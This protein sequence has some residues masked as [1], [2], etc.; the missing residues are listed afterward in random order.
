METIKIPNTATYS[1][2]SLM[3]LAV[4]APLATRLL[5]GAT[6]PGRMIQVAALGMYAGSALADW[7]ERAGARQIDFLAEF[8][9]DVKDL[10]SMPED[11]RRSEAAALAG[12][13]ND[14]YV[15][16]EM[17]REEM[18]I[19]ADRHLTG[20]MAAITDQRIETSTEIRSFTLAKLVF[21]FALGTCDV[22]SGDVAILQDAG[23]FEPH[24]IAHEFCHR[25]GYLKELHAQALAYMALAGSGEPA[26]E[27][28]ANMER[29]H[30]S[31]RV[32]SGDSAERYH[33][34]VDEV[35]LRPELAKEFH[36]LWPVSSPM[37]KSVSTFMKKL[38]DERM[39]LT[40]QNGLSDY[41]LGF[42]NFL[43]SFER[44]A[45]GRQR[46]GYWVPSE[47][48]GATEADP[49]GMAQA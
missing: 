35:Q 46:P 23:L 16:L 2:V 22:I 19:E 6:V 26:F 37:N 49:A 41:D 39:K 24:V 36:A 30:R 7:I 31:L 3:D 21:P 32:L 14:R 42:T 38:M 9:A 1:P 11:E 25:K 27:Q 20:F 40:G 18:A 8:G 28:S 47:R 15:P 48:A 43:Y 33:E 4:A 5:L 13:L 17:S 34:L 45:S 44:G 10:Q 12:R 29:L